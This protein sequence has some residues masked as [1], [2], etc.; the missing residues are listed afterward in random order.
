MERVGACWLHVLFGDPG[1]GE[2]KLHIPE[3]LRNV[4]PSGKSKV[5]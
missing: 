2:D 5:S 1:T 3:V 4:I